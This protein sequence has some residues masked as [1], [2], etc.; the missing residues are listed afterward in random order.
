MLNMASANIELRGKVT[1]LR[2]RI[3]RLA[4]IEIFRTQ[5]IVAQHHHSFMRPLLSFNFQKSV[6]V[7]VDV[8]IIKAI[9]S[10]V[11]LAFLFSVPIDRYLGEGISHVMYSTFMFCSGGLRFQN[12]WYL[13]DPDRPCLF[14]RQGKGWTSTK[15]STNIKTNPEPPQRLT[16]LV[17][18]ACLSSILYCERRSAEEVVGGEVISL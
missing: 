2:R 7:D 8:Q 12:T 9:T 11:L 1:L 4:W 6:D 14:Q 18:E 10:V 13:G 3:F 17:S 5:W 16:A 15:T